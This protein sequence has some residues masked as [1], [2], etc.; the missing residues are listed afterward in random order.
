MNRDKLIDITYKI[1]LEH[2]EDNKNVPTD[3]F[4][5]TQK[6]LI[7]DTIALVTDKQFIIGLYDFVEKE[8]DAFIEMCDDEKEKLENYD[9]DYWYLRE[10]YNTNINIIQEEQIIVSE[11]SC[12]MAEYSDIKLK[13]ILKNKYNIEDETLVDDYI[14]FFE[15]NNTLLVYGL[16]FLYEIEMVLNDLFGN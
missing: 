16:S 2:I 10:D 6:S 1:I 11:L 8:L 13:E 7:V 3:H 4:T 15:N 12:K 5:D 14:Q 9:D